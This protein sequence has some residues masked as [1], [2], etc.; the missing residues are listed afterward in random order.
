MTADQYTELIDF[1]SRKFDRIDARFDAVEGR[2]DAV[3]HRLD[4]VE[5]RLTKVEVT[6]EDLQHQIQILAEGLS[7]TNNR[8]DRY[9]RDH[10]IRIAALETRWLQN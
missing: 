1:L 5:K 3:E 4:A 8:L 10:E 7:G 9:H 6:V 2:L